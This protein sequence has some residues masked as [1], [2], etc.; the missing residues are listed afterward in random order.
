MLNVFYGNFDFP[1][2][3]GDVPVTVVDASTFTTAKDIYTAMKVPGIVLVTFPHK[4]KL[5]YEFF[6][7][8]AVSNADPKVNFVVLS[9][10]RFDYFRELKRAMAS[11]MTSLRAVPNVII[12]TFP[13]EEKENNAAHRIYPV[14]YEDF[15]TFG[16]FFEH[17]VPFNELDGV[18]IAF[19]SMALHKNVVA[20][21][22]L[23]DYLQV[24]VKHLES[25]PPENT[26]K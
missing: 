13:M 11:F 21:S 5:Y 8:R 25:R 22:T 9:D 18:P 15:S 17:V 20:G 3:I 16:Q 7:S 24:F 1:K 10:L 23:S 26:P 19:T 12:F 2:Y 6:L 4:I 14:G